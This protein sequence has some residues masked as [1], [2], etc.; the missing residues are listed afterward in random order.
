MLKYKLTT[1]DLQTHKGFQWEIGKK[2]T[3]NGSG[4]LCS[5]GWLHCYTHPL[6]A[7]LFNRAHADIENPKLF[8]VEVGGECKKEKG[9]KE[10]YTE[11][12]LLR[13]IELP[14]VTYTQKIAFG[15]LCKKQVCKTKEWNKRADNWLNG[16]GR[17]RD[18]LYIC[19]YYVA[20]YAAYNAVIN[21]DSI[22][23]I[24]IAEEAMKY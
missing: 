19:M 11:M 2:V 24:E 17:D 22:N 14:T 1:Q 6:L 16:K 9:L 8:E 18:D 7:V 13:E 3:T 4:E 23:L 5:R 12:T 20:Y 21:N 15:I 10:G